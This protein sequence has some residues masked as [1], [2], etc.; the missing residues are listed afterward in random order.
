M[1]R[2]LGNSALVCALA[3]FLK[4]ALNGA[5]AGDTGKNDVETLGPQRVPRLI[6][7]VWAKDGHEELVRGA[8]FGDLDTR[9]LRN[10][11][12]AVE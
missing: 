12:I 1:K 3:I 8:I 6:Y 10:D 7:K 5:P 11:L 9:T 4:T 2:L